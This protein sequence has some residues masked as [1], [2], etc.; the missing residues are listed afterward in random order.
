MKCIRQ[1]LYGLILAVTIPCLGYSKTHSQTYNQTQ[2]VEYASIPAPAAVPKTNRTTLTPRLNSQ[3]SAN[4]RAPTVAMEKASAPPSASEPE[5]PA[6]RISAKKILGPL[7]INTL[8]IR[9]GM[10]GPAVDILGYILLFIL[11]ALSLFVATILF[12]AIQQQIT[13]RLRRKKMAES[14][15]KTEPQM[16]ANRLN[17]STQSSDNSRLKMDTRN[18]PPSRLEML[19]TRNGPPSQL[20]LG[21]ETRG[22]LPSLLG[23]ETL[24]VNPVLQKMDVQNAPPDF[25]QARFLRKARVYFLR[26]QLAWDKS[27][28][29]S[30]QQF[31]S[32]PVFNELRRQ[33]LARGETPNCTDVL[34]I[35]TQLLGIEITDEHYVA[36]VKFNGMIKETMELAEAPFEETWYLSMP[37]EKKGDWVLS[38]ITQS[39]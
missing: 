8:L 39:F 2:E 32:S 13:D 27:D 36:S 33:I 6:W 10:S 19:D 30:I 5:L 28:L 29:N 35:Q 20:P 4:T 23:S 25:D 24:G 22:G 14:P 17:Q 12:Q 21:M 31:A 11:S 34:S 37:T 3:R 18:G 1:A 26:L 7:G 16:R 38:G 9:I 15:P